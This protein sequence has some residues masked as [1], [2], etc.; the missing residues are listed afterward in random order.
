MNAD[1]T[2]TAKSAPPH[3]AYA[4]MRLPN[5]RRYWIGNVLA[6]VGMQMQSTA[7]QWEVYE[8][9]GSKM[10]LAFVPLVQVAP[11]LILGPFA[12]QVVDSKS[13][14]L[15]MMAA[16]AT[17]VVS[18]TFM[19]VLSHALAPIVT[20]Y[21]CV[22]ATGL[23][24][25]FLNPAKSS[26]MPQIA[27]KE[28]FSGAVA[29]ASGGFHLASVLG[30]AA[31]GLVVAATTSPAI[32]Y[33]I[34]AVATAVFLAFLIGMRVERSK[35]ATGPMTGDSLVAGARYVWS[36]KLLLGAMTLD[37]FA[38]LLG[39][40]ISLL[41]VYA[42]DILDVGPSGLG[43]LRAA[44]A[45]GAVAMAVA[46]AHRPPLERA[47]RDLLW[48]VVGF[49]V[50]TIVFGVSEVYLLSWVMLLL[51]GALD[52]I[53][54][55]VRQTLVQLKTPDDMRGRVAAINNMFIGASNEL[56][57]FESALVA[58]WFGPVFSVVSGGIGT[59][60]VVAAIAW[61][62]PELRRYGRL[63]GSVDAERGG[64]SIPEETKH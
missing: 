39:G 47:G 58:E 32:V 54:V 21:V 9:T 22:G 63:D 41:P 64:E 23:A 17:I 49:G 3:D 10:A 57:G 6:T 24:R 19:A 8:R 46:L 26:F 31:G 2:D 48:A 60:V 13:R 28:N 53:S 62:F 35:S 34:E 52:A 40:A 44:P 61:R 20:L 7:L 27:P 50:A 42:K 5:F 14:R 12:G 56:G 51:T 16:L 15:V 1:P 33:A 18:S 37:M 45:I 11:V 38:V 4:P 55:V 59:L 25:T 36:V 30:P 29:W 43:W